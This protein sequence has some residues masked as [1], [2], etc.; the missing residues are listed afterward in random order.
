MPY[1]DDGPSKSP[2]QLPP[3]LPWLV[4]VIV[5]AMGPLF[6]IGSHLW[7]GYSYAGALLSGLCIGLAAKFTMARPIPSIRVAAIVLVVLGSVAGY[8]WVDSKLW[9]PFMLNMSITRF[10]RDFIALLMVGIGCYIAFAL[11][12]PRVRT[13]HP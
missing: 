6:W 5:G 2:N 12:A 3:I 9:T 4:V 11:A 8:I 7:F 13:H 10:F 1:V